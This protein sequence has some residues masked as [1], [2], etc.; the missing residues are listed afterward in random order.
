VQP[1]LESDGQS[2]WPY[3]RC[4]EV[5]TA[6]EKEKLCGRDPTNPSDKAAYLPNAVWKTV[7]GSTELCW[8]QPA[9]LRICGSADGQ[10]PFNFG[11]ARFCCQ[12]GIPPRQVK[13]GADHSFNQLRASDDACVFF[14][15]SVQHFCDWL[16]TPGNPAIT[17]KTAVEHCSPWKQI[18]VHML[19]HDTLV[20]KLLREDA[21]RK[22][23]VKNRLSAWEGIGDDLG[24]FDAP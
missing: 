4:V 21:E 13:T 17:P 11:R 6:T 19:E 15:W 3:C 1:E 2:W 18:L 23:A 16:S 24:D 20:A 5:A 10:K 12:A 9:I 7:E 14:K 22:E 8:K